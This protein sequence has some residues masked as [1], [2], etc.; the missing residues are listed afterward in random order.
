MDCGLLLITH[1]TAGLEE[2]DEIVVRDAGSVAERGTHRALLA[3]GGLYRRFW[4]T[5]SPGNLPPR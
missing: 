2:M 1:G 3:G 4:E 5:R